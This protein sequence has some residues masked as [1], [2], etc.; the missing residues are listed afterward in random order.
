MIEAEKREITVP[1]ERRLSI[2][3]PINRTSLDIC[4]LSPKLR[5]QTDWSTIIRKA[6]RSLPNFLKRS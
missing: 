5:M 6:E 2:E 3:K 4:L 1:S